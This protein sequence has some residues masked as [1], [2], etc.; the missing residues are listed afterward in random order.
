[1]SSFRKA[2][3]F[4]ASTGIGAE[5]VR[6]LARSDVQVIAIARRQAL[7]DQLAG[8]YPDNVIPISIDLSADCDATHVLAELCDRI[9]GCDLYVYCAGIMPRVGKDDFPTVLDVESI[10]VNLTS[11][12]RWLNAAAQRC[13]ALKSGTIVGIS[14]V[15]GDRGRRGGPVYAATKAGFTVYLEALRNR[16]AVKGVRVVT[17]KPGPVSTPMTDGLPKLP[18]IISAD[19]AA[20]LILDHA[21]RGTAVA[22]VPGIWKLIMAIIRSIPQAVFQRLDI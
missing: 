4:G 19:K 1:M 12:V 10:D 21:R 18:L 5:L 14:S 15:A 17:I 9:G 8:E 13:L 11:A 2:I 16:L 20:S 6:Q 22:Y 7:L 3:V